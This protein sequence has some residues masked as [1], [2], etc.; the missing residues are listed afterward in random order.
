ML[1]AP[2]RVRILG[3]RHGA[4]QLRDAIVQREAFFD[5]TFEAVGQIRITLDVRGT[6]E[7]LELDATALLLRFFVRDLSLAQARRIRSQEAR[8]RSLVVSRMLSVA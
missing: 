4:I 6:A 7:G 2:K 3:P 1:P 5:Q 8:S